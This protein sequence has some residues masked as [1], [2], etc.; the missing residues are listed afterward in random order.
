MAQETPGQ[1][2]TVIPPSVDTTV[3][4]EPKQG[5]AGF[6]A[7]PNGRII[8]IAAA[9]GVLL[10]IAGV[11]AALVL[12]SLGR[13]STPSPVAPVAAPTASKPSTA[14]A[15]ATS[16]LE[17][18]RVVLPV[19]NKDVFTSRD[20]FMPVLKLLPATVPTVTPSHPGTATGEVDVLTLQD[21]V[22][23]NG[24]REALLTWQGVTYEAAAGQVLTETPW[25]VVSIGD[26]SVT[27]LFGD[28]RVTLG[29][30]EGLWDK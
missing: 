12:F 4:E 25:K 1:D 2:T 13:S 18:T 19:T 5:I 23:I 3:V 29:V 14:T 15:S 21:I 22:T 27:M 8:L 6:V 26:D 9:V 7:T 30:G 24:V 17:G 16:T 10:V 28:V 11:V 20:P